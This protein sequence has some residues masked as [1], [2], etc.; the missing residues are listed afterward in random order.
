MAGSFALH[1]M[2]LFSQIHRAPVSIGGCRLIPKTSLQ[3]QAL[4]EL[5]RNVLFWAYFQFVKASPLEKIKM[6]LRKGAEADVAPHKQ[7]IGGLLALAENLARAH[8]VPL[9]SGAAKWDKAMSPR[10]GGEQQKV[11]GW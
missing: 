8:N 11:L 6:K 4:P 1:L 10:A 3:S 9:S 7:S 5:S 2:Q